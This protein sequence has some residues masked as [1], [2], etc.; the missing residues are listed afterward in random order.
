[1]TMDWTAEA[2]YHEPFRVATSWQGLTIPWTWRTRLPLLGHGV[3]VTRPRDQA[4]DLTRLLEWHG[5]RVLQQPVVE[6]GP[7][8][9]PS[10]VGSFLEALPSIGWLVFTS[11]NGV[12]AFVRELWASGRD[13]R[14]LAHVQLAAI[15]SQTAQALA[16]VHLRADVVPPDFCSESLA[17]ALK[18]RVIGQR[19][20]L[21]RAD[22]G[23]AV[24][25]EVLAEVAAT[26]D[27]TA[28]YRQLDVPLRDAAVMRAIDA[29]KVSAITL[30]SGNIARGFL[31]AL[32]DV[33]RR[34]VHNGLPGL[35]TISPV[36]SA[37]VQEL[38][39]PVAAEADVFT[40]AGVAAAVVEWVK[41]RFALT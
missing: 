33:G 39:F 24:L 17:A 19:V 25:R 28:F 22:R 21:V 18:P 26:V 3:V 13:V 6:I 20:G 11:V 37:V 41:H 2:W 15:G 31:S 7:P 10:T 23:R 29:G 5:A 1:M 4:A 36:T 12:R 40:G 32:S 14:H 34:R 27:E 35:I 8:P 16:Q 38:G 30:T 9:D